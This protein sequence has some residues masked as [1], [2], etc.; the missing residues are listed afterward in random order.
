M[1]MIGLIMLG[2]LGLVLVPTVSALNCAT[3]SSGDWTDN[4]WDCGVVPD[5]D[6]DV[7]I[8]ESVNAFGLGNISCDS[9]A[10][11]AGGTYNATADYTII[12]QWD[13]TSRAFHNVGTLT[14]NSGTFRFTSSG[15]GA[16][17]YTPEG[18]GNFYDVEF[19]AA[20]AGNSL[21]FTQHLSVTIEGDLTVKEGIVYTDNSAIVFTVDGTTTI[22]DGGTF[23][24]DGYA[25]P[26][27]FNDL[28][29]ESGGVI[30]G[31]TGTTQINSEMDNYNGAAGVVHNNGTFKFW[32]S[33][34]KYHN[35]DETIFWNLLS[36]TVSY[37]W[38]YGDIKIRNQYNHTANYYQSFDDNVDDDPH[39]TLGTNTSSGELNIY[40][41]RFRWN[42]YRRD[43]YFDAVNSSHRFQVDWTGGTDG[44]WDQYPDTTHIY[45]ADFK[46]DA[47]KF[48]MRNNNYWGA[49]YFRN[50]SFNRPYWDAHNKFNYFEENVEINGSMKIRGYVL[51]APDEEL[52][53]TNAEC[54][55]VTAGHWYDAG[56]INV[57]KFGGVFAADDGAKIEFDVGDGF[58]G[59]GNISI[60]GKTPFRNETTQDVAMFFP[61][62]RYS[63]IYDQPSDIFADGT[64]WSLGFWWKGEIDQVNIH[65]PF[66]VAGTRPNLIWYL[67]APYEQ[68]RIRTGAS[69]YYWIST[70]GQDWSNWHHYTITAN[71][72]RH[73]NVYVDGVLDKS[74]YVGNT[75]MVN[76]YFGRGYSCC[77]YGTEGYYDNVGI[78]NVT[79]N[80]TEA[81]QLAADNDVTRGRIHW[82]EFDNAVDYDGTAGE[83]IN[84]GLK[85]S[86]AAYS[87]YEAEAGTALVRLYNATFDSD[88]FTLDFDYV[89]PKNCNNTGD[90]F[91][92]CRDCYDEGSNT[93]A[94]LFEE[95]DSRDCVVQGVGTLRENV[96]CDTIRFLA[97]SDLTIPEGI[98]IEHNESLFSSSS[99]L[100][101]ETGG[102]LK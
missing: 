40:S 93:G 15:A 81:A 54:L 83:I 33:A 61:N 65:M 23:G 22:E 64:E 42:Y 70:A 2:I 41:W 85:D 14:H 79:I 24:I 1:K 21:R 62:R 94:W 56:D 87:Y 99:T 51:D 32:N 16:K 55:N 3:N 82:F 47:E 19:E 101:I 31:S 52:T 12:D 96:S 6:D 28:T 5:A 98:E 90:D 84:D 67:Y 102:Y 63:L 76:A 74:T 97:D 91:A 37:D 10:I 11:V 29:I 20:A 49:L 26:Y 38:F 36:P 71:T 92:V 69:V 73:I 30:K 34:T 45:N 44:Y 95:Y 60:Q 13:G 46:T 100:R 53:I 78:F 50:V 80:E 43:G 89:Q 88:D 86:G 68:L 59:T 35:I 77:G 8:N 17:V 39:I 4:I 7:I 57:T 75:Y 27:V 18:F 9:M 58:I 72:S 25:T 48:S 66:G